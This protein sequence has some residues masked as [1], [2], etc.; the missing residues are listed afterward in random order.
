MAKISGTANEKVYSIP[1]WLGLNEHPD[2]DTRLKLGEAAIMTDW[3][4]TRDGNLKRRP[5]SEVVCGLCGSYEIVLGSFSEPIATFSAGDI[6]TAYL[7]A[8]ADIVPGRIVLSG[9]GLPVEG[10]TIT[11]DSGTVSEGVWSPVNATIVDG[12]A[13][14]Q[15]GEAQ[16]PIE[17][18]NDFFVTGEYEELFVE[19]NEKTYKLAPNCV[20][21]ENGVYSL[22]GKR[23]TVAPTGDIA[24]VAGMWTGRVNGKEVFL[25]AGGGKLYSLYD[26]TTDTFVRTVIGSL[27]TSKGVFIFPFDNKAYIL[28]GYEYYEW[29]GQI[30]KV[31]EG[32]SPVVAY[33]VGPVVDDETGADKSGEISAYNVNRL[34]GKR[35]VWLSPDNE[36]PP[37]ADL[38]N[39][40]QM[41][42]PPADIDMDSDYL[43]VLN[44]LTEDVLTE[45]PWD[46]ADP[47]DHSHVGTFSFDEEKG[48]V[49]LN[50]DEVAR[51][52]N[53]YEVGYEVLSTGVA[54]LRKQVT[55]MLF[56]EMYSGQT[57]TNIWLYGDGTNRT[58][59]S[60]MD[61]F[62]QAR[63]DYFPDQYE[64]R[65]GDENTPITAM[66]RHYGDLVCYKTDSCWSLNYTLASTSEGDLL[67][68]VYVTPVNKD[69]GN[70][71]PGQVRLVDN[72]PV[73]L[74][75]GEIYHWINSSYYSSNI[76]RDERQARRISDRVQRSIKS[77][78]LSNCHMWDDNDNQEFYIGGISEDEGG[79]SVLVWNYAADAWYK[80]TYFDVV[81]FASFHGEVFFG[82][83]N[84]DV[85][86]LTYDVMGDNG[87]PV[88]A[89]W[90]SGAIDFGSDYMRKY[91]SMMW[92]GLK[93]EEGTA[94]DVS[95]MTDRKDNFRDKVVSSE[96]AKIHGE[97][98]MVK[99]KIKAK[100]FVFY[101]L[102]LES[103]K[104]GDITILQ[105]AVTVTNVD[106]RVRQTGYTK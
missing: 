43:Y 17:D 2:G 39:V 78:D 24:P 49:R 98:F 97:P 67:P 69:K 83:S 84:G 81:S 94:V 104:E 29:D 74:S 26:E 58:I 64:A 18:L 95:V 28:N 86:R 102:V 80:Y 33:T 105:P 82:N 7:E 77:L 59:Y 19:I 93:P 89:K 76:S 57:D 42:D 88:E 27:N 50:G 25:A 8:Y 103:A 31:V 45:I 15:Q 44:L 9:G 36:T 101:R 106:F 99:T 5:G 51:S 72:N 79:H 63:A 100:K 6:V 70:L 35:R 73:T 10:G 41:P 60:G 68:A 54:A 96:R 30:F 65:V 53:S 92:V 85:M 23:L 47:Y 56:A 55:D 1:K 52:V 4:V 40:F 37:S 48:R 46:T 21:E 16:V 38:Q 91:S 61:E 20:S 66:I 71:A 11:D 90:V 14:L 62:G 13:L 34:T 32:Y 22:W 75:G 12:M 87:K 3:K